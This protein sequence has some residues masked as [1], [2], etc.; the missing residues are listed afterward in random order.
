MADVTGTGPDGVG[1]CR[2]RDQ[3]VVGDVTVVD[4]STPDEYPSGD[5]GM[6]GAVVDAAIDT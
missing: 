6:Y 2:D 1:G 4:V 5:E 3:F